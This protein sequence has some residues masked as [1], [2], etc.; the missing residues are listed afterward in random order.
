MAKTRKRFQTGPEIMRVYVPN[1][2]PPMQPLED[3]QRLGVRSG[4]EVVQTLLREFTKRL[5]K[6]KL[7]LARQPGV[8]NKSMQTDT[9]SP[10]R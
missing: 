6:K 1:Y 9:A 5:R 10:R 2:V 3:Q 7:R 4:E 8:P